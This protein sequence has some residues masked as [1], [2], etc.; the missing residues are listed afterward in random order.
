MKHFPLTLLA[1]KNKFFH[2]AF[3]F[4]SLDFFLLLSPF[5]WYQRNRTL[6]FHSVSYVFSLRCHIPLA[7]SLSSLLL[8]LAVMKLRCTSVTC[9]GELYSLQE[10]AQRKRIQFQRGT[11]MPGKETAGTVDDCSVRSTLVGRLVSQ[12]DTVSSLLFFLLSSSLSL[13]LS[14]VSVTSLSSCVYVSNIQV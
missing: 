11:K 9:R 4:N 13:S 10:K 14:L 7:L 12:A 6:P 3:C 5:S 8:S 1:R 2:F